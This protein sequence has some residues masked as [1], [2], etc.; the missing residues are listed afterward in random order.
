MIRISIKK[1]QTELKKPRFVAP[2][3]IPHETEVA[4]RELQTKLEEHRTIGGLVN[5]LNVIKVKL[6]A[7]NVTLKLENTEL[8]QD[9][10]K[11]KN[12]LVV[13]DQLIGTRNMTL[14]NIND[15]LVKLS[16]DHHVAIAKFAKELVKVQELQKEYDRLAVSYHQLTADIKALDR[17]HKKKQNAIVLAEGEIK[18]IAVKSK[19]QEAEYQVYKTAQSESLKQMK[20][21]AARINRFFVDKQMKPPI[22]ITHL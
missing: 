10:L 1:Q 5:N 13:L 3:N 19:K 12:L 22:N 21:Y 4:A 18:G 6:E 2:S 17:E 8:D 14:Q 9:I 20:F 15:V 16:K 7:R 11:K